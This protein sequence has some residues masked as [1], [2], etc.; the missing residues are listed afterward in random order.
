MSEQTPRNNGLSAA[1]SRCAR[2]LDLLNFSV[3]AAQTVFGAFIG[4]YLTSHAWTQT[5]I[6]VSLSIGAIASMASQLPAGALVDAV[7]SKI[8]M[9][10][11]GLAGIAASALMFALWP[12]WLPV[13]AAQILHSVASSILGPAI[14]AI[15]LALIGHDALGERLGLSLIHI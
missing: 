12:A 3:A 7:P 1:R 4:V 2:G 5:D 9:A 11:I 8:A 14:A 10:M 15:S 6:G 13:L